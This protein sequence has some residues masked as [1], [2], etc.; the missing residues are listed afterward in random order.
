MNIAITVNINDTEQ[1]SVQLNSL[2]INENNWQ[3]SYFEGVPITLTAIAAEG[4]E[5][6]HWQGASEATTVEIT[7]DLNSSVSIAP[8]FVSQ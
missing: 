3:G 2:V 6:S 5:F 7:V 1:G 8:I 4:F